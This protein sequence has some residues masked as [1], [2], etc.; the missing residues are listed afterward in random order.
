MTKKKVVIISGIISIIL[1]VINFAG[2]YRTC[3]NVF[4]CT[5][6]LYGA[7][8]ILF[9]II[10]LLVFSLIT[11]NMREDVYQAWWKFT[12]VWIPLSMLAVLIS[13]SYTANWLFPIEKGSVAFI[14]SCAFAV[15]SIVIIAFQYLQAK[16]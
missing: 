12:R 16:K 9:P 11:Y 7:V 10:P 13:P 4:E 6:I 14:S 5:E 1:L 2:I 3:E 15:V 8:L